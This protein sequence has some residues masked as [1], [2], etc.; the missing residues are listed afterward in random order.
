MFR[1]LLL[2]LLAWPFLLPPGMCAVC[3]NEYLLHADDDDSS[4]NDDDDHSTHG[5][6]TAK[7]F[8]TRSSPDPTRSCTFGV[9]VCLAPTLLDS[10]TSIQSLTN[11][12]L[13]PNTE[14]MPLFL[15]HCALLI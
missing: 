8:L 7:V 2:I 10:H 1:L 9:T 15:T 14:D 4:S 11:G 5:Q 3:C 13:S 12:A 6:G